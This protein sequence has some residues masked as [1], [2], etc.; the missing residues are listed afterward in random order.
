MDFV[1]ARRSPTRVPQCG[2]IM[3][4][5][6]LCHVVWRGFGGNCVYDSLRCLRGSMPLKGGIRAKMRHDVG[7]R[8]DLYVVST[9]LGALRVVA[10]I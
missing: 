3:S 8:D 4:V 5:M 7:E 9:R 6:S 2:K 10:S 1:E